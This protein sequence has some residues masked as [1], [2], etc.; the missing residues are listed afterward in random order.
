[1]LV[2]FPST[3]VR[4]KGRVLVSSSMRIEVWS[5]DDRFA[6]GGFSQVFVVCAWMSAGDW[7]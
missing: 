4:L 1:M 7:K 5:V 3:S 2:N 6:I